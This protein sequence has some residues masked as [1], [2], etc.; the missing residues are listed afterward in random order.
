[1]ILDRASRDLNIV[2]R[3]GVV[4]ELLIIFVPFA[5]DQNNVAR[6][7]QLNSA[8]NGLRAIDN[9]FIVGRSKSLFD[10]GDYR[11]R[12]F[13]ARIVRGDDGVISMAIH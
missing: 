12:I 9:F 8:I 11:V 5:G 1:M 10:L 13:F 6:P 4:R 7:C 3:D 2:E